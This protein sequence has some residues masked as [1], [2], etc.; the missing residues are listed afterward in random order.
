M[1]DYKNSK[2]NIINILSSK[3][4]IEKTEIISKGGEFKYENGIR[5]WVGAIFV[6]IVNS[7]KL[8]KSDDEKTVKIMRAFTSEIITIFQDIATYDRIGVYGD[9]IYAICG[10]Q[11]QENLGD[12]FETACQTNTFLKMF[13]KIL[14]KEKYKAIDAG[15]GLGCSESLVIDAGITGEGIN[16]RIWISRAVSDA[17]RLAKTANRK[18]IGSIAMSRDFYDNI[19]DIL[20]EED[21][22]YKE[23]ITYDSINSFYHC[24][25]TQ[26]DFNL[27][28][29][30]GMKE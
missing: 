11:L 16:D 6:D 5:A 10:A 26:Y 2:S 29:N 23:W 18:K 3:T 8:F 22:E 17:A 25:I 21:P 13:N 24:N 1:Y 19:I 20:L 28:V 27:W 9:C 7:Q 30:K 15:I 12:I 14:E 4:K